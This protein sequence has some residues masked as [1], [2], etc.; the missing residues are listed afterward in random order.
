MARALF[1]RRDVQQTP[2]RAGRVSPT[3]PGYERLHVAHSLAAG[4]S[5]HGRPRRPVRRVAR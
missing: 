2:G 4:S 1:H 3:G 5:M